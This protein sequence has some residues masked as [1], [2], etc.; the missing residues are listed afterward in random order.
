VIDPLTCDAE[1]PPLPAMTLNVVL[2]VMLPLI[3]D[4]VALE[5]P[6]HCHCVGAPPP[7]QETP[8]E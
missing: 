4:V 1:P 2:A 8:R 5:P 3:V 7:E 6:L